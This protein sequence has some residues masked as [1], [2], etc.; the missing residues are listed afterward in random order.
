MAHVERRRDNS[1]SKTDQDETNE[2]KAE[3]SR[4]HF[5]FFEQDYNEW[6][7]CLIS[8]NCSFN[9]TSD[10]DGGSYQKIES[11]VSINR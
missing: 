1:D 2:Y 7:L 3:L 4:K 5:N 9:H 6:V 10:N 8:D 11:L